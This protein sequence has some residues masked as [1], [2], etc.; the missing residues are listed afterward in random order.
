MEEFDRTLLN[1]RKPDKI[2]KDECLPLG[3]AEQDRFTELTRVFDDN[4][5]E[6]VKQFCAEE[7]M[8]GK[9]KGFRKRIFK[10]I[11]DLG[12]AGG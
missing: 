6:Y 7:E 9:V 1:P 11:N 5:A 3:E 2:F 8:L 12:E 4:F 10:S